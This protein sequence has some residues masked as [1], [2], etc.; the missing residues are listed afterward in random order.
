MACASSTRLP[1]C[2]ACP[3]QPHCVGLARFL[4]EGGGG[5][6]QGVPA[7]QRPMGGVT[8]CRER[9][10]STGSPL[11][12]AVCW[13]SLGLD[14][15]CSSFLP[16]QLQLKPLSWAVHLGSHPPSPPCHT[17][18]TGWHLLAGPQPP[19]ASPLFV[20]RAQATIEENIL[21]KSDQKRQLDW[22]AIQSGGFN[23]EFLQVGPPLRAGC[24]LRLWPLHRPACSIVP[25]ALSP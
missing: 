6:V 10:S 14:M 23:T 13:I 3:T 16:H 1:G 20:N 7:R 11:C 2:Q 8:V 25:F 24:R 15:L 21:R 17:S 12:T 18:R 5:G 22:L 4:K 9:H 19:S